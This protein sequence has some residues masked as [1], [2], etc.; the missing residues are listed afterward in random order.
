MVDLLTVRF[1]LD[2][3]LENDGVRASDDDRDADSA[4]V[5]ENVGSF[6]WD[7]VK[8]DALTDLDSDCC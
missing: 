4:K 5:E 6:V 1:A 7:R 8:C 2:G 3:V